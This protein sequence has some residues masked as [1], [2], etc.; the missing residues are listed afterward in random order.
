MLPF[1]IN[2]VRCMEELK[3][4][5]APSNIA[6]IKIHVSG[7]CLCVIRQ[8]PLRV[9]NTYKTLTKSKALS[10]LQLRPLHV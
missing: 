3:P 6:A 4:Q 2:V 1:A 5:F 7:W 8:T 9:L 10:W